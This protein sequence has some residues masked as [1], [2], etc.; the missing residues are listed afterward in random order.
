M[1]RTSIAPRTTSAGSGSPKPAARAVRSDACS[2]AWSSVETATP[3][4][5]PSPRVTPYAGTPVAMWASILR[6]RVLQ[7][8]ERVRVEGDEL[9]GDDP[10]VLLARDAA[11]AELDHERYL[12]VVPI[13]SARARSTARQA[14]ATSVVASPR[15]QNTIRSPSLSRP[16][17]RPGHDLAQLGVQRLRGQQ[18][19]PHLRPQRAEGVVGSALAPVV[20]DDLVERVEDVELQACSSSHTGIRSEHVAEPLRAQDRLRPLE[21]RRL[22]DDVGAGDGLLDRLR[23]ADRLPER[24]LEP[25]AERPP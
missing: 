13:P 18:P 22:D 15:C 7:P 9:A 14:T 5:W 24:L 4:R 6:A 16:G 12:S 20:D 25:L 2:W 21:P 10:V 1:S 11:V 8:R 19:C 23:H 17:R 3:A